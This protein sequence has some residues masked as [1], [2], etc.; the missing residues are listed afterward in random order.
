MKKSSLRWA[1]KTLVLSI[2]LSIVFSMLSQ[3]LF[4]TLSIYL[5]IFIIVFFIVIA[6]IF[7]MIGV[8]VTSITLQRI[9]KYK[10]QK[11][12]QTAIKL[13]KNTDKVSSFCGDVVGDICGILSGAGAV[14]LVLSMHIKDATI[15][16]IVTCLIS[17]LVAGLTIFGKA[18]MKGYAVDNCENVVL[19][20]AKI[21]ETPVFSFKK[22]KK[23]KKN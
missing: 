12:Y 22:N 9:E 3:S 18:I 8:A 15:Y 7:D 1:T 16:F 17:S 11:G 4:P 2:C 6:V 23:S 10:G 13:C 14:S 19:K 20:T 21:L 5:S